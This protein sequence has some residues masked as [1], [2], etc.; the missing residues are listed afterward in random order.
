MAQEIVSQEN[1]EEVKTLSE[2]SENKLSQQEKFVRDV[3][4][5]YEFYR[6][7]VDPET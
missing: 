6:E 3:L 5:D 7:Y 2:I 1:F 4:K